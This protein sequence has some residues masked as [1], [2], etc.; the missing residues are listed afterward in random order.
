MAMPKVPSFSVVL[1]AR[2]ESKTLPRL[3][4][5]LKEFQERGGEIVLVDTGSTDGT[6]EVARK[7]GCRVSEEGNR[8]R[9]RITAS[10]A[11]A[12]NKRFVVKGEPEVL[13]PGEDLFDYSAARNAA[14]ALASNDWVFCPDCDEILTALDL[15]MIESTLADPDLTRL[16]YDFIFSHQA[17]GSPA[18]AFMHSK[19][20]RRDK[21]KWQ[22]IVH[23][24]LQNS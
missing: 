16:E 8:F 18:I 7:L 19:W 3:V 2:N 12:I 17:D 21:M 20:Y 22:G 4:E 6:A 10:M 14:A 24:V 11:G 9:V 1:I 5:S 13:K 15:D 23:E